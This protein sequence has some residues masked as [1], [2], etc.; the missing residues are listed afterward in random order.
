[1]TLNLFKESVLSDQ[2]ISKV[3]I[4][5]DEADIVDILEHHLLELDI[6]VVGFTDPFLAQEEILSDSVGVV[7]IDLYMPHLSGLDILR[8]VRSKG[9]SIPFIFL[10]GRDDLGE[11][12]EI[13]QLGVFKLLNKPFDFSLLTEVTLEAM[14]LVEARRS[15]LEL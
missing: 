10:T 2:W 3:L 5:D 14:E 15:R 12:G 6:P 8:N 13:Y 11:C 7:L 1:M 4:L 9:I